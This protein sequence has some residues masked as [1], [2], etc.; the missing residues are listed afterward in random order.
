MELL[1]PI[2]DQTKDQIQTKDKDQNQTQDQT[3]TQD[4]I[5]LDMIN[6]NYKYISILNNKIKEIITTQGSCSLKCLIDVIHGLCPELRDYCEA[7]N[8]KFKV[9]TVK[10][11]GLAGKI[12]EYKLFGNLP[13][14]DSCPDLEY[15]DIKTTH[16]KNI[17]TGT[18]S[19]NAKE[20]LTLTNFGDPGKQENI[21]IISDKNTI[22][23][24]KFYGKIKSGI[25]LIFQ[26]QTQSQKQSKNKKKKNGTETEPVDD[27]TQIEDEIQ[28]KVED[29]EEPILDETKK[30]D[31][32]ETIESY[33]NKKILG[34]V[35]YNLD[36]V[37]SQ[38]PEITSTFQ[39]DFNKIKKCI[40]E[41]N[42]TQAGQQYLHIHKHGCKNGLTR[43][44]GFTNKFLTRLVSIYL[45]VP[46]I[47]KGRSEYIE[48]V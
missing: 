41:K 45:G 25:I 12:V 20:R 36:D 6:K 7:N 13:N 29:E 4:Q 19:F 46:L 23:E 22:Q 26:H 44:F 34:I 30:V 33:D 35:F 40:V 43:A 5:T 24:T 39:D 11:K 9:T 28:I 3:Q 48:F 38:N 15:G 42:V 32:F 8:D 2:Q 21:D 10:D 47:I 1:E 17:N 18:K 31:T 14:S 16:F 37:F 27:E